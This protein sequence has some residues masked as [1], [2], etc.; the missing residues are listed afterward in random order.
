MKKLVFAAAAV[1]LLAAGAASA[2]EHEVKMLNK[3]AQ[4]P[5]A[6]EPQVIRIAPG[7]TVRFLATDKGHN[8]ETLDGM[9]PEG[10]PAFKGKMN[11]DVTVAFEQPGVYGY[12]CKPHYTMGMV[13]LVVVGDAASNLE[14]AKLVPHKGRAKARMA[15]AFAAL[16]SGKLAQAQ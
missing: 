3:G 16:D 4:G 11:Q 13:G 15:E 14:A 9:T 12:Q 2:A 7:D 1:A 5:M 8:A 6:F 10:A